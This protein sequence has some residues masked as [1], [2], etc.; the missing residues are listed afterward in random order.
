MTLQIDPVAEM[1]HKQDVIQT[2][3]LW[4]CI[5]LALLLMMFVLT[6]VWVWWHIRKDDIEHENMMNEYRWHGNGGDDVS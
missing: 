4:C 3:I 1:L 6:I 5:M 2:S